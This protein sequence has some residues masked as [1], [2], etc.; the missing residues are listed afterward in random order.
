MPQTGN[1][2]A[3][4]NIK[5]HT[6]FCFFVCLQGSRG[7]E[8]GEFTNLQ[9]ISASSNGRVVVAD[10][11]N[12]CIQ[13]GKRTHVEEKNTSCCRSRRMSL[14][15]GSLMKLIPGVLQWRP[16][17]DALW[18]Q[19][20][21]SRAAAETDRCHCGHERWHRCGRLWQS[22]G[23]HLL[24][25]WEVQGEIWELVDRAKETARHVWGLSIWCS[26]QIKFSWSERTS[27]TEQDWCW[28]AHGSKGCGCGQ[29][30][31]HHH[32]G[33]QSLLCLHLSVQ[34]ETGD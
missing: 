1:R 27:F 30:W 4:R 21:V 15:K 13:V 28:P 25:W 22:M 7:R 9:G 24:L 23:Q 5:R 34:R 8:K 29:E 10:S 12:Q 11:N 3:D 20:T 17:Q 26:L 19:R 16:V 32:R 2:C 33:Q 18:G 31:T 6:A 14:R